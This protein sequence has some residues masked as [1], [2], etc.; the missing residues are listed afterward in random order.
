VVAGDNAGG[1]NRLPP[2]PKLFCVGDT[3]VVVVVVVVVVVLDGLGVPL[4]PQAAVM[5][6]IATIAIPPAIAARRRVKSRE[7][8]NVV[9]SLTRF[10]DS[11]LDGVVCAPA[12]ASSAW[13]DTSHP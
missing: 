1:V 2:L 3:E 6:P 11:R 13:A 5:A 9:L 8:M 12:A 4:L 10:A 7:L